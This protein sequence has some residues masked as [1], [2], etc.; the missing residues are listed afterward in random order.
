MDAKTRKNIEY[1][2]ILLISAA[3][4]AVGWSN[5]KAIAGWGNQNTED[6][7]PVA[8]DAAEKEDLI[9]E[10]NSVEDYLTF[11]RSVNKGNTYK[12]QY[13]NLN[14]DLDLAEV[15]EDLVIGNAE[16]TQYCFQGIFDGNGHHLSNVMITSDTDAGTVPQPGRNGGKSARWRV[17]TFRHRW[18]EP[19]HPIQDWVPAF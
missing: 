1:L 10:I 3:V 14:A 13:V 2:I 12:G 17:V 11:V 18:Q 7:M 9:L 4:L 8:D 19:L 15:E 16:N 5:R 6:T